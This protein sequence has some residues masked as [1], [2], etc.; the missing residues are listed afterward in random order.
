MA[1]CATFAAA[2][3]N[4]HTAFWASI[5]ESRGTASR[6]TTIIG[7]SPSIPEGFLPLDELLTRGGELLDDPCA[8]DVAGLL[9]RFLHDLNLHDV[10]LC[11]EDVLGKPNLPV[12]T[13]ALLTRRGKLLD[14]PRATDVAGLLICLLDDLNLLHGLVLCL[15]TG[16]GSG[17]SLPEVFDGDVD[18]P[19]TQR[20][21]LL[22]RFF[23]FV[24][25]GVLLLVVR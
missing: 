25:H 2:G 8:S 11:F 22:V 17:T 19:G 13:C 14:D 23:P 16:C 21:L 3:R 12:T 10:V 15:V 5:G 1:G 7:L 24:L 20:P 9:V 4:I 6:P 18:Q